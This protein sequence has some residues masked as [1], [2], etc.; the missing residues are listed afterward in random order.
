MSVCL[1][2]L[3]EKVFVDGMKEEGKEEGKTEGEYLSGEV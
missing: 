2:E 3:D 1:T